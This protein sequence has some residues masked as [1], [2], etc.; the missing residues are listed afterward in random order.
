MKKLCYSGSQAYC[1]GHYAATC[2]ACP[3][4]NGAFWCNGDCFWENNQCVESKLTCTLRCPLF[5]AKLSQFLKKKKGKGPTT[6]TLSCTTVL[7]L[8]FVISAK[9]GPWV[10]SQMI[11]IHALEIISLRWAQMIKIY[12]LEIISQ[13]TSVELGKEDPQTQIVPSTFCQNLGCRNC[14]KRSSLLN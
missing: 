6:P 9:L 2:A 7:A 14:S 12:A 5:I 4:G 10:F 3:G 1:G 13:I 11:K 8:L